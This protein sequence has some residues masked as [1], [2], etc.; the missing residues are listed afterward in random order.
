MVLKVKVKRVSLKEIEYNLL[1]YST[2]NKHVLIYQYHIHIILFVM[3]LI[4]LLFTSEILILGEK[5][6]Q[7]HG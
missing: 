2:K 7:L 1:F 3:I 6:P 5:Y 4:P